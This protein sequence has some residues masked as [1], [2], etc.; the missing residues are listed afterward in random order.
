MMVLFSGAALIFELIYWSTR[1]RWTFIFYS[2]GLT[3]SHFLTVRHRM[4]TLQ[5]A[6][7]KMMNLNQNNLRY[8]YL[9]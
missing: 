9:D 8:Q 3:L 2:N 6:Q 7:P 5:L 1:S 4:T